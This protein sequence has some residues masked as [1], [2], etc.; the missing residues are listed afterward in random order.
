MGLRPLPPVAAVVGFVDRID[1]GELDDLV[2]LMSDDHTLV[3]LDGPPLVGRGANRDAWDADLTAFPG[4]VIHPRCLTVDGG[5]VAVL[6]ATTGSHLALPDDEE[7]RLTVIWL[8]EVSGGRV[9][10]WRIVDDTPELRA[11]VGIPADA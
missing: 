7:M 11:Q 9:S 6:G 2:E 4:D 3:V 8:A 5:S 10:T 1:R